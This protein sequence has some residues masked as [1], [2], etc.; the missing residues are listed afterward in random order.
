LSGDS[1]FAGEEY[2]CSCASVIYY[3]KDGIVSITDWELGDQ[4]HCHNLEWEGVGWH[5]DSV[6]GYLHLLCE[7]FVLLALGASL[8]VLCDPF[9]H[10]WPPEV[11]T[12]DRNG[13]VLPLMSSGFQV[14]ESVED[15]FL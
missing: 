9:V 5:G 15:F 3:H 2:G 13:G 1:C 12:D 6:K 10:V 11:L 14:M 8:H 4:V 7:V